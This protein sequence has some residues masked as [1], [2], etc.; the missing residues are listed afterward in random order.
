MKVEKRFN[1]RMP[2]PLYKKVRLKAIADGKSVSQ[3]IRDAVFEKL[4]GK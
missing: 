4:N 2:M 1:M 3:W